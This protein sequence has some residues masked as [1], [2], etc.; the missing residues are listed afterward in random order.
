MSSIFLEKNYFLFYRV[1][2]F[3]HID[4]D[5]S[6]SSRVALGVSG[7]VMVDQLPN[8]G[9][10]KEMLEA[11]GMKEIADLF[12]DLPKEVVMDQEL[13][14]PAPQSEEEILH[15][16]RRLLGGNVPLEQRTSF[17]GAGLYQN[18]VPSAIFQL[19]TR[20][21]F[22]TSYTPYQPEVSQGMLQSMWEFQTLISELVELPIANLSMYDGS[23]AAAEALTTAVRVLNRKAEQKDTVYVSRLVPPDRMSVIYNY[24][25]GAEIKIEYIE[26]N[27][28]GSINMDSLKKARGS[29]GIYV[30]YPNALGIID[31]GMKQVKEIIGDVTAF[32]I[33]ATPLALGLIE[34]PGKFGADIVVGEGQAFGSPIT[35]GGPIYGFFAVT[36]PFL[37]QMPGRIV[38]KSIDVDGNEAFCLTLSTREQHIRRQRATSN[39]CS[40]E[41]LIALMGAMH[42]ALLG[43]EG[44]EKLAYRN[45]AAMQ[46]LKDKL[47]AVENISIPHGDSFH[48]NEFVIELPKSA[49][50]C[51]T[52]LDEFGVIAGMDMAAWGLNENWLLVTCTDQTTEVD[53]EEFVDI[54]SA[55]ANDE[56]E[57][58]Q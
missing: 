32:I 41:T 26:H 46:M 20:G 38:G 57:V 12:S 16:A 53:I 23:T 45:L 47:S 51:I 58:L 30:E 48:F 13:P 27:Q 1:L 33:G 52:E 5:L 18:F 28:D 35:G 39:I 11:M 56:L 14:L 3:K 29:C 55:W 50:S 36:K 17:L 8:L 49:S 22:L 54:L 43:P 25:Q 19:I 9:R 21:E 44:L 2:L 10:E 24:T 31:E 7:D 15:D 4:Y 42:M 37:R 34:A 6:I 40:N